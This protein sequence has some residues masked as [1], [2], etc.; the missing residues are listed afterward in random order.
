MA[1]S[2]QNRVIIV[3][4]GL[5]GLA[6]AQGFKNAN[7]PIPFHV[8]ERDSSADF[9]SQ[10]YRIRI[11]P[12]GAMALQKLL[13][14]HLWKVFEDSCGEVKPGLNRIDASTSQLL[15]LAPSSSGGRAGPPPLPEGKSY[16]ADRA[17]LRN[18][19]LDGLEDNISF[20]K[21]FESYRIMSDGNVE[22]TF[23]DGTKH[24][25]AILVGA[26]GT[27]SSIRRQL[28]PDFTVL[29]TEGRAIF[30]KTFSTP[31]I[32]SLVST[33][34]LKGMCLVGDSD[35]SAPTLF[36]DVMHFSRD[37]D[38]KSRTTYKVPDDYI[39]WVLCFN[40]DF[41][42]NMEE[43]FQKLDNEQSA[44]KAL[45]M[46]K[47]WHSNI[48][49]LFQNQHRASSSTLEFYTCSSQTFRREWDA[50]I[51]RPAPAAV[52]LLGDAAHPMSPI[53]GVGANSAFQEA[54]DLLTALGRIYSNAV[55]SDAL[56]DYARLL[57]DR[58]E[59]TVNRSA[60]GAGNMFQMKPFSE[61]KAVSI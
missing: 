18:L 48:K 24:T 26:D 35:G 16:N 28:M 15:Q 10:G 6:L 38:Q 12:N 58:G 20:E 52:T 32:Q 14:D 7:P 54:A 43:S 55:A 9:R 49:C 1:A 27:R 2:A 45:E 39:Y 40:K 31:E 46:S 13:P 3:G 56:R 29:D 5:G 23:F 4:G 57:V 51:E 25:G 21:R 8:F 42:S 41:I 30:G 44:E 50:L 22:V 34:L 37:L 36:S 53:G 11:F 19:L 60:G 47:G 33:E 59:Q 17:V 61:L